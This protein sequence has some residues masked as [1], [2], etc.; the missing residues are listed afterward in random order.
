MP[1]V[2]SIPAKIKMYIGLERKPSATVPTDRGEY[3]DERDDDRERQRIRREHAGAEV[4]LD[5]AIFE[6]FETRNHR[7]AC[8]LT[9]KRA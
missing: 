9:M 3:R 4:I 5:R 8:K 2:T 7:A 1:N 6:G